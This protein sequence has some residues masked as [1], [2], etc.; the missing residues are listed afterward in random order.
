MTNGSHCSRA[1]YVAVCASEPVLCLLTPL[2]IAMWEV[3][4]LT[5]LMIIGGSL[6]L[7]VRTEQA[8]PLLNK[9]F[10]TRWIYLAAL[11]RLMLGAALIASAHTV[12]Y[13]HV[14]GLIG[15]LIALGGLLLVAVPQPVWAGMAGWII[16]QPVL[17]MRC[18]LLVGLLFGGFVSYTALA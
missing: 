11:F 18:W 5:G 3:V 15:W 6:F 9:V 4:L 8:V 13:P 17:F 12:A 2:G 10:A 14:I 1:Q 7:L 16:N